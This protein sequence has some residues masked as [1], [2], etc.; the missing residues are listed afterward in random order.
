GG[1]AA[2]L[3]VD[4]VLF[5]LDTIK[6][7]LQAAQGFAKAG[8]FRGVYKGLGPQVIGS[9]PQAALFFLTYE[10]FKHYMEPKVGPHWLPFVHMTGASIAE[11]VA[12]L[13]RVPIEV[14]KQ[15]RQT[16]KHTSWRILRHAWRTEDKKVANTLKVR[17]VLK[18]VHKELG[19]RGLFA[20]F[21][22]RVLWITLGGYI[23]FGMYDLSK[24]FCT[25]VILEA[26]YDVNR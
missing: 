21:V 12:C 2:G 8:G 23:F 19:I 16:S 18:Q 10:S 13:I 6:T 3:T 15:R 25:D 5:P 26:K 4:V 11:V 7:R 14:V 9:A 24:N 22:P 20:G 17:T 1:G